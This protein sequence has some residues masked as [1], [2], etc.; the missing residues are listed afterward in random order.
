MRSLCAFCIAV[1][2][3][4]PRCADADAC[5]WKVS[6]A[7]GALLY[8]GGS[9]HALQPGDYPLPGQYS[10]AL[11]A[12]SHLVL[13]DDPKASPEGSKDLIKAG[14]Y[15]KGDSLKNHVDP[16]TYDYLR[17]FFALMNVPEAKFMRLK[18]WF[19][20]LVL[21]YPS[22]QY[23]NLGVESF[24]T[25][26]AKAE[27]KPVSGLEG[28]REHNQVFE[29]LSDRESEA[30]LLILFINAAHE[31][32]GGVNVVD[33]WRQGDTNVLWRSFHD[34]FRDFPSLGERMVEARNRN[35]IPKIEG[36]LR[37]GQTYFVVVGAAHMG[38]PN[39]VLALLRERGFKIEQL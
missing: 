22:D 14:Q 35:W 32:G 34:G 6:N 39:G 37:S 5:V 18:P 36:Y 21:S 1:G 10:R 7:N 23:L 31:S 33:A 2:I 17:H 27:S 12:S 3:I 19:I 20:N 30:L 13:E 4:F 29:A 8:L 11:D 9:I 16:R 25:K 15:Q 28:V 38:G 24:L 26:R